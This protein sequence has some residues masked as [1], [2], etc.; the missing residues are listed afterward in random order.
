MHKQLKA[1]NHKGFLLFRGNEAG[2]ISIA[3]ELSAIKTQEE[4]GLL[5]LVLPEC[6]EGQYIPVVSARST[7]RSIR[8]EDTLPCFTMN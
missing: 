4:S 1:H 3:L 2:G 6:L 8:K 7:P 5:S